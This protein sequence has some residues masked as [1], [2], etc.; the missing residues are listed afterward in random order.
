MARPA[1]DLSRYV[2]HRR[3]LIDGLH[4]SQHIPGDELVLLVFCR[5]IIPAVFLDVTE[6]AG[7]SQRGVELEHFLDDLRTSH[8]FQ[9]LN[10]HQRLLRAAATLTSAST[11]AAAAL[12]GHV[13]RNE[14]HHNCEYK[15]QACNRL[16]QLFH[17]PSFKPMILTRSAEKSGS[18]GKELSDGDR[19]LNFKFKPNSVSV[20]QFLPSDPF[21]FPAH[22]AD[23]FSDRAGLCY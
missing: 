4:H 11:T 16:G 17:D 21:Q 6:R 20:T 13:T 9:D 8:P 1:F 19:I 3:L 15:N 10:I 2:L 5:K 22:A 14:K 12:R 7:H 18:E 23:P